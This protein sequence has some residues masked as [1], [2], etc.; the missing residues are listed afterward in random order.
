[1]DD[2]SGTSVIPNPQLWSDQFAYING[3]F[4]LESPSWGV[5]TL[6]AMDANGAIYEHA[7]VQSFAADQLTSKP[8]NLFYPGDQSVFLASITNPVA[9]VMLL[10]LAIP[11]SWSSTRPINNPGIGSGRCLVQPP[12]N[13]NRS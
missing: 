11:L 6:D 3:G 8:I 13:L 1:V 4:A 5:A 2:F 10:S 12:T 9:W 7:T